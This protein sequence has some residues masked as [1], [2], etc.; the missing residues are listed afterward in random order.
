[1]NMRA[2]N[3]FYKRSFQSGEVVELDPLNRSVWFSYELIE[4]CVK[5]VYTSRLG[6]GG[7]VLE[8]GSV[9][10]LLG[11]TPA[12]LSKMECIL[13]RDRLGECVELSGGSGI[14]SRG[15]VELSLASGCYVEYRTWEML[16]SEFKKAIFRYTAVGNRYFVYEDVS[17]GR[18][19]I[20]Y[21]LGAPLFRGPRL[22][23]MDLVGYT[24]K[25]EVTF[26]QVLE[27]ISTGVE[28]K[29][30][31]FISVNVEDAGK[32]NPYLPRYVKE[33]MLLLSRSGV[34]GFPKRAWIADADG[35]RWDAKREKSVR[36]LPV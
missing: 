35:I 5:W 10:E 34:V 1:M 33:A 7:C 19:A 24:N 2:I 15:T 6:G 8:V 11:I 28:V 26:Y 23:G 4:G 21:V 29:G 13:L 31:P 17:A 36:S 32:E 18:Y 12:G 16:W 27:L 20:T 14:L 25:R 30:I 9:L 3:D 22:S